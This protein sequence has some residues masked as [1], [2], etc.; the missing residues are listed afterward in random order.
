MIKSL[1]MSIVM[2]FAS[3][4]KFSSIA[5]SILK[6]GGT[7]LMTLGF[8]EDIVN[9]AI[10]ALVPILAGGVSVVVGLIASNLSA[11]KK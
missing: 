1:I 11:G 4:S 10:E 2:K 5:R 9:N 3:P 7:Y 8:S 6:I